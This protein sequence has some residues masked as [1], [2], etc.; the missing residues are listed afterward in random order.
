VHR[1]EVREK[2]KERETAP[3][4]KQSGKE[5]PKSQYNLLHS[6]LSLAILGAFFSPP[7]T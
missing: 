4:Q 6:L 3:K 7:L 5:Y 2:T 1:N